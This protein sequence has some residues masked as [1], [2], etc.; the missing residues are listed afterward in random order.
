M[1]NLGTRGRERV[2]I[3]ES[4]MT[5]AC[6]TTAFHDPTLLRPVDLLLVIWEVEELQYGG[7]KEGSLCRQTD[8]QTDTNRM[9]EE[10][11]ERG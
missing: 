1:A 8:R 9:K 4:S 6:C 7:V 11:R 3:R 10:M 2:G 5:D